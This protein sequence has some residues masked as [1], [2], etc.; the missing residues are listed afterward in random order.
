ML[1]SLQRLLGFCFC[2]CVLQGTFD[3]RFVCT[4]PVR[5]HAARHVLLHMR[6]L[7]VC[8]EASSSGGRVVLCRPEDVIIV[9]EGEQG[10]VR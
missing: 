7:P 9:L 1:C 4:E 6:T 8:H 2:R 3:S 5:M 10:G